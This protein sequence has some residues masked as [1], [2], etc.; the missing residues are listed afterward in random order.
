MRIYITSNTFVN[1]AT[2]TS[3]L[4]LSLHTKLIAKLRC[5]EIPNKCFFVCNNYALPNNTTDHGKHKS[6]FVCNF[7]NL[8]TILQNIAAL[9][10]DDVGAVTGI[11]DD[12]SSNIVKII[13]DKYEVSEKGGVC[14]RS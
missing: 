1:S 12:D 14:L 7:V 4:F 3:Q 8:F 9:W 11:L 13:R 5:T 6:S 10:A 2:T